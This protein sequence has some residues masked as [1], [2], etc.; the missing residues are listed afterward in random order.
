MAGEE[1]VPLGELKAATGRS[2]QQ[3]RLAC[4]WGNIEMFM[5]RG[6]PCYKIRRGDLPRL[7]AA[8]EE[9]ARREARLVV[10]VPKVAGQWVVPAGAA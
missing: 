2:A 7:R 9:L 6:T 4:L 5:A 3:L 10:E 8:L 1:L